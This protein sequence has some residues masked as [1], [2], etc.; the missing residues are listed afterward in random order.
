MAAI[1][2]IRPHLPEAILHAAAPVPVAP[3]ALLLVAMAFGG[4]GLTVL[5]R[6]P[7][8]PEAP[9]PAPLT[10]TEAADLPRG[11]IPLI[12]DPIRDLTI[13]WSTRLGDA[14]RAGLDS[15]RGRA[16][17]PIDPMADD[18]IKTLYGKI[19]LITIPLLTLGGMILGYLI[20]TSRTTG[21]SAYTAR[22]V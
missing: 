5:G 8:A 6:P 18:V 22:A 20:M 19:L 9:P 12:G 3:A 1:S 17:T 11:D 21:E 2:R 10:E 16:L 7:V 15:L 14:N 13:W 4:L